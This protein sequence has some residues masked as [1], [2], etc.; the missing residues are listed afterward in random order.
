MWIGAYLEMYLA[1]Q[2]LRKE[3]YKIYYFQPDLFSEEKV[4]QKVLDNILSD[5]YGEKSIF[6]VAV[7]EAERF[8]KSGKEFLARCDELKKDCLILLDKSNAAELVK[9][10]DCIITTKEHESLQLI[11]MAGSDCQIIYGCDKI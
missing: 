6:V 4:W 1:L 2:E 11:D 5:R 7:D 3:D 8:K 10:V 9:A